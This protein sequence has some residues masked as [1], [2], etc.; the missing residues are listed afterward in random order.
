MVPKPFSYKFTEYQ[1]ETLLLLVEVFKYLIGHLN[2]V[3]FTKQSHHIFILLNLYVLTLVR[4][5]AKCDI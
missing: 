5:M 4:T 2:K 1:M 3:I